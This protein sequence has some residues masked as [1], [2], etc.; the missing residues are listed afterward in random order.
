[1]VQLGPM[2]PRANP[3]YQGAPPM[4][5]AAA[6]EKLAR[7]EK[8]GVS[9]DSEGY[10]EAWWRAY[11]PLY[12][13]VDRPAEGIATAV[14]A[15]CALENERP[16]AFLRTLGHVF[17]PL[18]QWDWREEARGVTAP[19]LVIHGTADRVAPL[20]GGREWANHIPGARLI[21]VQG[22]GHLLWAERRGTVLEAILQFLGEDAP[23]SPTP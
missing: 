21:P 4:P 8:E 15:T 11:L 9:P 5:D 17:E 6:L 10:C 18:G 1:M 19:T 23:H 7:L 14:L 12:V 16:P 20:E 22:A 3:P 13:G 2:A